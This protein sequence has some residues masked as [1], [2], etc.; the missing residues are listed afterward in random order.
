MS[1]DKSI[2]FLSADFAISEKSVGSSDEAGNEM[3]AKKAVARR[4]IY[5]IMIICFIFMACEVA[6]GLLAGSLAILTDAAHLLSDA[7]SFG[8]SLIALHLADRPRTPQATYGF[9]RIEI[10]GAMASVLLIWLLT[11]GLCWEAVNRIMHPEEINGEIMFITALGGICVNLLMMRTLHGDGMDGH[12][13]HSHGGAGHGHSHGG[14]GGS[15]KNYSVQA[16]YIHIL[17]DFVQS[18]GVLIASIMIWANPSLHLAD[19]ICTFIFSILVLS[20]TTNIL[21]TAYNTLLNGAPEHIAIPKLASDLIALPHV[22]NVHDLHIWS[23]GQDRVAL[24]AHIIIR[25]NEKIRSETLQAASGIAEKYAVKHSTFQI[26][27]DN[28][29]EH[30]ICL[31]Y[32]EHVDECAIAMQDPE[33]RSVSLFY[34]ERPGGTVKAKSDRMLLKSSSISVSTEAECD[35][36]H[37]HSH[38]HGHHGHAH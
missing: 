16:A 22:V 33:S 10:F 3:K 14:G 6:G 7:T 12:H 5:T 24:T 9:H 31:K 27:T 15:D 36:H 29:E 28:S 35:D 25:G 8:I 19:P 23:F 37:G 32:N 34:I 21:Y 30:N 13:G 18:L 4:K 20:T 2:S 26:E 17:G 11:A 38:D 1:A